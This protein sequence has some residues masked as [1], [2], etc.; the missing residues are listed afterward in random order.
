MPF[1]YS[2]DAPPRLTGSCTSLEVIFH[3][4]RQRGLISES[5]YAQTIMG[6][7]VMRVI[8]G[9]NG[10]IRIDVAQRTR[11]GDSNVTGSTCPISDSSASCHSD[12]QACWGEIR[13]HIRRLHV[14]GWCD[15]IRAYCSMERRSV[16]PRNLPD[17]AEPE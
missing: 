5:L 7:G 8:R 6:S 1:K 3:C 9:G 14:R 13:Q 15:V 11:G 17:F 2:I 12:S 10:N 16:G 4:Q